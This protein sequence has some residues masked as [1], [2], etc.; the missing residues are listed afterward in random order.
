MHPIIQQIENELRQN[1]PKRFGNIFLGEVQKNKIEIGDFKNQINLQLPEIFYEYYEWMSNVVFEDSGVS[2]KKQ[3]GGNHEH[4]NLSL[5]SILAATKEWQD[6]KK[7]NSNCKWKS[8]FM[9]IVSWGNSYE[10]VIDTKGEVGKPG[11]LLYWN[12]K[13]DGEY[14][15]KYEDF[16]S[17]LQTKLE[18]LE[19]KRFFPVVTEMKKIAFGKLMDGNITEKIAAME[20]EMYEKIWKGFQP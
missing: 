20:K 4:S 19:E 17:F 1:Y 16:E 14:I 12:F 15:V 9:T 10:M 7:Y 2:K 18:L 11:T 6:I 13:G 8:G 3:S 5:Q